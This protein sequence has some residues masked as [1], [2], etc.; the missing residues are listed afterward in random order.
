MNFVCSDG[1]RMF[2]WD[3]L[4]FVDYVSK[5]IHF[6]VE[7]LAL[8]FVHRQ[9]EV[10]VHSL[11]DSDH[12]VCRDVLPSPRWPYSDILLAC[13]TFPQLEGGRCEPLEAHCLAIGPR[14]HDEIVF[15]RGN[16]LV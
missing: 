15:V 12:A 1:S 6:D 4:V 3:L 10:S 14:E 13:L 11:R 9:E 8:R 7:D 16:V 5:E 2:W